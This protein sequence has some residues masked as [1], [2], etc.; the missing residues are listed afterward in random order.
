MGD[1]SYNMNRNVA[2]WNSPGITTGYGTVV[3]P[4]LDVF[5]S[6]SDDVHTQSVLLNETG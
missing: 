6:E 5:R 4:T 3:I 2:I 1:R